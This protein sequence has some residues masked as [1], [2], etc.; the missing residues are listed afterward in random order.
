MTMSCF[1][2]SSSM[3]GCCW[4]S[5]GDDDRAVGR[6]SARPERHIRLCREG[7]SDGR[8]AAG[9]LGCAQAEDASIE[10]GLS[11]GE[12]VVVD[13]TEKLREGSKVEVRTSSE[14]PPRDDRRGPARCSS[15]SERTSGRE[16]VAPVYSP[17]GRHGVADGGPSARRHHRLSRVAGFG[18]SPS[19]LSDHPGADVLSR[20]QSRR[21]GLFRHG[22]A[23]T[24]IRADARPET[25]DLHQFR[26]QLRHHAC[27]SVWI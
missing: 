4:T 15:A 7:R 20:R 24:A 13:G 18:T 23:R 12:L 26:R 27:S 14:S 10:T 11:P 16:S 25:D 21:H 22:A 9:E 8:R 17:A 5:S 19:R 2:I 1:P 3:R 6:D